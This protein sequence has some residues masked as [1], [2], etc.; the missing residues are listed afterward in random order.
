MIFIAR[1]WQSNHW[2]PGN[3]PWRHEKKHQAVCRLSLDN[4]LCP[5]QPPQRN[6]TPECP[7]MVC[8]HDK[9]ESSCIKKELKWGWLH[10]ARR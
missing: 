2:A 1:T 7:L 6:V 8:V 9:V 3:I 4:S 10:R 5:A